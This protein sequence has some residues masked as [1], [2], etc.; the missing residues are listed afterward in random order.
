MPWLATRFARVPDPRRP[1][2]P[3][4]LSDALMSAFA[5]FS[6]KDPSLLAFDERRSD[7][8]LKRLFGIGQIP[9]D[10]QMREILDPVD[11]ERLAACLRRRV[12][13]V[14]AG[15][16][17]GAVRLLQRRLSALAGRDRVFLFADDPLR[18]VPGERA[19]GRQRDLPAP[20]VGG[21]DRASRHQGG[22]PPG[23]R[24]D[25]EA[26][27]RRQERLRAE[28][29]EATF[30]QN[31]TATSAPEVHRRRGRPGQQRP[32]CPRPDR[33][34]DAL[35]FGR[36]TRR[37]CVFVRA[38][39]GSSSPRALA[40]T[41]AEGRKEYGRGVVGVRRAAERVEPGSAG[42][43]SGVQRVQRGGKTP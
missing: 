28:R 27:R 10:T 13:P 7:G 21:G 1:G 34:R 25:S 15:Q 35:H 41:L 18:V 17:P 29:G 3:I 22:D 36:Q 26:G 33:Q 43:L 8:N 32:A 39:G 12:P 6:L 37:S 42:G 16:S 31:S 2:S 9:S 4:P 19:Q 23:A 20:D 11:P 30:A 38:G 5:M 40:Q 24:A 14:A